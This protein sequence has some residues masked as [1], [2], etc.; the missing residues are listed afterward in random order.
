LKIFYYCILQIKTTQNLLNIIDS[1]FF[2]R[3]ISRQYNNSFIRDSTLK[4]ELKNKLNL[5]S[6]NF[7]D[8]LKLQRHKLSAHFQDLEFGA[9][10][11][12]WSDITKNEIDNFYTKIL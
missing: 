1:D 5:L 4:R 7:E 10:V 9:R 3:V 12:Y 8:K 6:D 11:N 2:A